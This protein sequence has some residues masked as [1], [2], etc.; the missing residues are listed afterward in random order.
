M[1]PEPLAKRLVRRARDMRKQPTSAE[2]SLWKKLRDRRLFEY[3]WRRQQCFGPFILDFFCSERRVAVELD[4]DTRSGK[5][6]Y[7]AERQAWIEG[8]G[9]RVLRFANG[10]LKRNLP[11]VL[12]SIAEACGVQGP[13]CQ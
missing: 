1:E 13:D 10:M 9:V 12:T 11:W 8:Q 6:S 4:G 5:E 2:R 3:K 7:D